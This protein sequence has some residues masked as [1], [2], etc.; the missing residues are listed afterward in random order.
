MANLTLFS[1]INLNRIGIK[2]SISEADI[3]R[4]IQRII[5]KAFWKLDNNDLGMLIGKD[6]SL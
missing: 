1:Q 2:Y 5:Q 6:Y 4:V 3:Q